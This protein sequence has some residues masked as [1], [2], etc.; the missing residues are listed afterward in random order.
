MKPSEKSSRT[1]LPRL[2]AIASA[3]SCLFIGLVQSR[4][5]LAEH[6]IFE[7]TVACDNNG[8]KFKAAP[9][10][11]AGR[12]PRAVAAGDFN[13]DNLTDLA[14][15]HLTPVSERQ[16]SILLGNGRG[17]FAIVSSIRFRF[18]GSTSF[19]ITNAIAVGDLNQD[20]K[21][22][23]V[24]AVDSGGVNMVLSRD[25]GTF[26]AP[27]N[28]LGGSDATSAIIAD[29][30]GDNKND[31][32]ASF[33][34]GQVQT[35][36]GNGDGTFGQVT[37]I[38]AGSFASAIGGTDLNNDGKL[39]LVV[40]A[41]S[42]SASYLNNRSGGF[43]MGSTFDS[44]NSDAAFGFGDFNGDGKQDMVAGSF[45]SSSLRFGDGMGGF[46]QPSNLGVGG[47]SFVVADMN[48]DNRPD[49]IAINNQVSVLIGNG[50]TGFGP[51]TDYAA[52]RLTVSAVVA[53]FNRDG[54]PD[55]A[56]VNQSSTGFSSSETPGS[57]SILAGDSDGRLQ[58]PSPIPLG[59]TINSIKTAD[60]NNDGR[61][62]L[63]A[64]AG[65]TGATRVVLSSSQGG[66]AAPQ[67]YGFTFGGR[68]YRAAAFAD[69]NNDGVTDLAT[70]GYNSFSSTAG[71]VTVFPGTSP[72]VFNRD[73]GV[74]HN[75]GNN[76]D[77]LVAADFN[78]DGFIDLATAN[79][80]SNDISI[81]F[82]NGRGGFGTEMKFPTG[83]EPRSIVTADFDNDNDADL[84]VANRNGATISVLLGDGRGA[85]SHQLIGIGANPR[86]LVSADINGD[87]KPD[88]VVPNNNV[89]RTSVLLNL[90]SG[91]FSPPINSD[92]GRI[93]FDAAVADF[94]GDSKPDLAISGFSATENPNERVSILA[95]DGSGKFTS[96][97]EVL[98]PAAGLLAVGD[99]NM[100]GLTDLTIVGQS[101][102]WIV[103]NSCNTT[104]GPALANVSAASY[105]G[106]LLSPEMIATAFGSGFTSQRVA[107]TD[108][109]L[110]TQLGGVT[111]KVKDNS[112]MERMSPLFFASPGQINY[113]MP[114]GTAFGSAIVTVIGSDGNTYSENVLIAPTSPSVFS[115]NSDGQGLAAALILR[116]KF[117]GGEQ[118][119][120]PVVQ[121]NLEQEKF[122]AFPIDFGP[123][124]EPAAD[125]LFLLLFGTGIRLRNPLS[126]V[127]ATVG[128][129]TA[130]VTFA[131]PHENLVGLDQVNLRL[132][133]NL[134]GAGEVNVLLT[135]DGIAANVTR[136]AFR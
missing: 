63:I 112:G 87:A 127:T 80:G 26:A 14:V 104:P 11:A 114:A 43:G 23:L 34:N 30:N 89:G 28:V 60:L 37:T 106:I 86:S 5:S 103:N 2:I 116:I 58:S 39:D 110:P 123:G 24:I 56:A 66:V 125:Q 74:D 75:I 99:F 131:G 118:S 77:G 96:A 135:V 124:L 136:V 50:T 130:Q 65:S 25:D 134:R 94:T 9:Q 47:S 29:I 8:T 121:F 12:L 42:N 132:S 57:I 84:A 79:L 122:V 81:L 54:L 83:L 113:Q 120:E 40:F 49:L 107:A 108:L 128:N 1:L 92:V 78:R 71:V 3:C 100:D 115:A 97:A 126:E 119:F 70:L 64:T 48:K 76:P 36:P 6:S 16:L 21:Q 35:L 82:N 129:Q 27:V 133:R 32:S 85:F 20:N 111:V 101:N 105:R 7:D 31:I 72:G 10:I 53:D 67:T 33:R 88:L 15:L 59:E 98:L 73:R 109:P 38:N 52:G 19:N 17:E 61:P 41:G 90:G 44:G 4:A 93:P 62:D 55:V 13:G 95:G 69:F 46:G 68:D 91:N 18:S 102:V 51:R 22:D 117:P 45:S